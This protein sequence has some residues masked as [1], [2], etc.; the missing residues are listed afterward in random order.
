M[1]GSSEGGIRV[2]IRPHRLRIVVHDYSGHPFQVQLS[3]ELAR[4]GHEV[5]HLH[6][7]GF[8]TPKGALLRRPDDPK[9]FHV[10]GLDLGEPFAKYAFVKRR[11]QEIAYGDLAVRRTMAFRPDVVVC[12]N[13]PLDPLRMVQKACQAKGI[14]FVVWLQ[15]IYS[16]AMRKILPRK[17]PLIGSAVAGYFHL[18]ERRILR[19][20]DRIVS[21]T[22]DFQG[23]LDA[24]GVSRERCQVVENWAPLDEITPVKPGNPWAV[25]QGI[26]GKKVVLYSGTLGLKHNP[27]RI[28]ALAR[29]F[30]AR[31]DVVFVVVSEGVGADWLKDAKR[32]E[33]LDNL[34]LLPFQPYSRLS[35]VLASAAVLLA[36][37]EPDAG[38]FSVPS[39]VLSYLSAGRA[40]LLAVPPENLAART[41]MR[42]E[43]GLVV[44]PN[45]QQGLEDALRRLLDDDA[46]RQ[47]LAS[48]AR[49]H[50]ER[51]FDIT[52]IA[53]RF[54]RLWCEDVEA[55][56]TGQRLAA[57]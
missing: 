19:E 24:W 16:I 23:I 55:Y 20:A 39:K 12:S 37:I 36:V 22:E 10:E 21:I 11:R 32:R 42:A 40:I 15:D 13:F 49:A 51:A 2:P 5:L 28:A 47:R 43:A 38:I 25:E 48:H 9:E 35:E 4:R 52:R 31:E 33:Q 45:D 41:V 44:P 53:D 6:F 17:I 29:T 50:A 46:A 18:L 8:Q 3:R 14:R 26:A 56:A 27:G 30:A 1:D 57:A 54:E 7:A 34:R